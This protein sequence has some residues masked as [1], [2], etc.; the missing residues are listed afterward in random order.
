MVTIKLSE[1]AAEIL[2]IILDSHSRELNK[3]LAEHPTAL[4]GALQDVEEIRHAL[5]T[6][7][8]VAE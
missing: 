4:T 8:A 3:R 2:G 7:L 1:N 5:E 6:A